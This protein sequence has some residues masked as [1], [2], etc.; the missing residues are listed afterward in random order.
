MSAA[1]PERRTELPR[2]TIVVRV[3]PGRDRDGVEPSL[4]R[5]GWTVVCRAR[6][7]DGAANLAVLRLLAEALSLPRSALR[8]RSGTRSREKRIEVEGLGA[9]DVQ[10]RLASSQRRR[11]APGSLHP[12]TGEGAQ[13][14]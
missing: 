14:R 1:P 11:D 6:A 2:S 13:A 10:L 8:L 12:P 7:V 4:G 3:R 5:A 9:L